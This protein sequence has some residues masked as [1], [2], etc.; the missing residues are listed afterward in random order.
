MVWRIISDLFILR[1]ACINNVI[2]INTTNFDAELISNIFIFSIS[3]CLISVWWTYCLQFN[4]DKV[5]SSWEKNNQNNLR[6]VGLLGVMVGMRDCLPRIQLVLLLKCLHLKSDLVDSSNSPL[7]DHPFLFFCSSVVSIVDEASEICF[8]SPASLSSSSSRRLF[9]V[10][11]FHFRS[12]CIAFP[13]TR[14]SR[15]HLL[16]IWFYWTPRHGRLQGCQ[17]RSWWVCPQ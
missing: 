2:L 11:N 5:N 4:I 15:S 6:S 8:I 12:I 7:L 3:H 16:L 14:L 10:T 9:D 17:A 13:S 1:S